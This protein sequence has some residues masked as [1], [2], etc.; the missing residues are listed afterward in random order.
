M[1]V[2]REISFSGGEM[3]DK[4]ALISFIILW[5]MICLLILRKEKK[6]D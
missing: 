4:L 2:D 5:L 1:M 6:N 3:I